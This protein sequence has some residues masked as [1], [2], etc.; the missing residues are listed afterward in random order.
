MYQKSC[1]T[2][3]LAYDRGIIL[4]DILLAISLSAVFVFL[5]SDSTVQAT[6]LFERSHERS[7]LLD[8]FESGQPGSIYYEDIP[9]GNERVETVMTVGSTTSISFSSVRS[10]SYESSRDLSS[11]SICS[12]D[13]AHITDSGI[14]FKVKPIILPIDPLLPLTDIEVRGNVVYVSID[15]A[16]A[17][18]PDLLV[19]DITDRDHVVM[20]S[21]INTGPG[22]PSFVLVGDII[23]AAAASTAFQLHIIDTNSS[24]VLSLVNRYRI[25][26]PYATAT[27]TFGSAIFFSN[28]L[29][30]FGTEKWAGEEFV[31]LD[32]SDRIHPVKLGGLDIDTKINDIWVKD[33][34]A[35][36]A[37]SDDKQL[38]LIDVSHRSAPQMVNHASPSGWERQEGKAISVFENSLSL[39]RTSGGFDITKDH[40]LFSWPVDATTTLVYPYSAN[41]RGGVYGIVADRERLY[42]VTREPNKELR[43]TNYD[44]STTTDTYYS[45]PVAPQTIA[46]HGDSLY[47]L[48]HTAPVI[49]EVTF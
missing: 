43:I 44:L 27:P 19:F 4:T 40:E 12:V 32:V 16:I 26:L 13:F 49:Y 30:Y 35:Y 29:L 31:L 6:S 1:N 25:P 17:A 14:T 18:D 11:Q 34:H 2:D 36:I 3:E 48:A 20:K 10:M 7:V 28:D 41:I 46:C 47:L 42:V 22:L 45:L 37:A 38:R 8:M 23:Y 9:F 39:G 24:H 33:S 21:S 5:L 15:S